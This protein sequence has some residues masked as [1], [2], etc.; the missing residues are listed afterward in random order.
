MEEKVCTK[1]GVSKPNN[2]EY[3]RFDNGRL[4]RIC[5]DCERKQHREWHF[6]NIEKVREYTKQYSKKY[7]KENSAILVQKATEYYHKNKDKVR[8]RMRKYEKNKRLENPVFRLSTSMK[9]NIRQS[10]LLGKDG[11]TWES[12]V[13]YTITDLIKHIERKFTNGMSWENYGKWHIDHI[14]PISA[15]HFQT[16]NDLDFK[17]CWSLSNL[18]PMWAKENIRKHAK[19]SRPFQPSLAIAV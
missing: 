1:C 10:L 19:I 15:F 5:R 13:G 3:F 18:Q 16:Y 12:L 4:K 6:R 8:E 2:T 7:N 14:I 17:R 11:R 9:S